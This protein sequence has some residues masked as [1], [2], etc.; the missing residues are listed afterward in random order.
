[1]TPGSF[2]RLG[3]YW[4]KQIL[5][6]T[7]GRAR[8]LPEFSASYCR[9]DRLLPVVTEDRAIIESFS[10]CIAC[11]MCDAHFQAYGRVN[12]GEFRAPSDL[13]LGNA[14][15]LPDF[16]AMH[17]YLTNLKEG[18]L[19]ALER[20]CPTGVPFRRLVAFAEQRAEAQARMGAGA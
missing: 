15:S 11:G 6:R 5:L 4:F 10:R 18:D 14:R 19:A 7:I 17:R 9:E 16:D 13:V 8:G 2:V 12:R 1:M 3:Y 20:I